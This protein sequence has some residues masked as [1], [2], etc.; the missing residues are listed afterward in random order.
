[1]TDRRTG[2]YP[3]RMRLQ[4]ALLAASLLATSAAAAEPVAFS[5]PRA[6]ASLRAGDE[7][8]VRWTGVPSDAEEMELLL[9]L[10]GGKRIALR[11]TSEIS[12]T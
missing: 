8:E 10:D 9:S 1:M 12:A 4:G 11:L 3:Q 6:G 7:V 2:S 5:S